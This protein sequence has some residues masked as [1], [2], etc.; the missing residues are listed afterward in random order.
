M[1][2][3]MSNSGIDSQSLPLFVNTLFSL[4]L[5]VCKFSS[6]LPTIL[7]QY[8]FADSSSPSQFLKAGVSRTQSLELFSLLLPKWLGY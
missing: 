2:L 4:F 5:G 8:P 6:Y 7:H 3:L 1:L